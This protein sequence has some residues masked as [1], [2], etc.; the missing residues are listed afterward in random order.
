VVSRR[1]CTRIATVLA[2]LFFLCTQAQAQSAD[3][4]ETGGSPAPPTADLVPA[5]LDTLTQG[6]E[7]RIVGVDARETY[8]ILQGLSPSALR[9]ATKNGSSEVPL[10]EVRQVRR[11]GDRLWDGLAIG[12]AVGAAFGAG[13]F[14]PCESDPIACGTNLTT[15]RGGDALA[16][17]AMFS[18][19]GLGIDALHQGWRTVYTRR[20]TALRKLPPEGA[21]TADRY[22]T[23]GTPPGQALLE[24]VILPSPECCPQN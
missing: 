14:V 8:G 17:A 21:A 12:A 20:A 5:G 15:T 16:T 7:L 6:D 2:G 22:R 11:R 23:V 10:T 13:T 4:R 1:A 9:V 19:I 3:L 18:A 24:G